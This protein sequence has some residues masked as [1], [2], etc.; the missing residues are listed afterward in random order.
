[1]IATSRMTS[2]RHQQRPWSSV[3]RVV[4]LGL[5]LSLAVSA[6]GRIALR[7]PVARSAAEPQ[8][9]GTTPAAMIVPMPVPT[10]GAASAYTPLS[11][12]TALLWSLNDPSLA[13]RWML[14]QWQAQPLAA[15]TGPAPGS[16]A[17]SPLLASLSAAAQ[18][19]PRSNYPD[20]LATRLFAEHSAD[21]QARALLAFAAERFDHDPAQRWRWMAHAV[22]VARH[23]LQDLRLA[24]ALAKQL[25][26]RTQ[27]LAV[28]PW[29]AT[30]ELL[31]I[32]QRL[33]ASTPSTDSTRQP[34][35]LARRAS[36]SSVAPGADASPPPLQAAAALT[37]D[38]LESG[39]VTDPA[40]LRFLAG[41]LQQYQQH[42]SENPSQSPS[43]SR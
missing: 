7:T 3:P 11:R 38:L 2:A 12:Q 42:S 33:T 14:L 31:I 19:A 22:F 13:G 27:G 34:A 6:V 4:L 40:E 35:A 28:P 36:A 41:K 10:A 23:R 21:P 43:Q 29:V 37:V 9:S 17:P 30:Q 18:L 26:E 5:V 24:Q 39:A 20:L 25:R 8:T 15:I 1:M 16:N 32:E